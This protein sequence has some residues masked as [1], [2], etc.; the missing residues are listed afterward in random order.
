M[1]MLPRTTILAVAAALA[2]SAAFAEDGAESGVIFENSLGTETGSFSE[3]QTAEHSLD[4]LHATW[5]I[6]YTAYSDALHG[7]E[8]RNPAEIRA[9]LDA[10]PSE[11]LHDE[12]RDAIIF[13]AEVA[14]LLDAS[15]DAA[16]AYEASLIQS[17]VVI[18]SA[19]EP[20]PLSD[21]AIETLTAFLAE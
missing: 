14:A 9:D 12:L 13:E 17:N 7:Y 3:L 6:A 18:L 19:A 5:Q 21:E 10:A 4:V 16:A 2:T 8:G 11:A 20:Q 15:N 1:R